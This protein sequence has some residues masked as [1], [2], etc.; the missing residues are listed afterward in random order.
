MP[1][2]KDFTFHQHDLARPQSLRLKLNQLAEAV[3]AL[4]GVPEPDVPCVAV[5]PSLVDSGSNDENKPAPYYL[6]PTH[7]T[8][9][10]RGKHGGYT[11]ADIARLV[12]VEGVT[13][14]NLGGKVTS[15]YEF[16]GNLGSPTAKPALSEP[17]HVGPI[18]P[19]E[20]KR[21]KH[22]RRR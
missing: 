6:P 22:R 1:V 2:D 18:Q 9:A 10:P 3:K 14:P 12:P 8:Q 20:Q 7:P 19:A 11:P 4:S 13:L 16:P 5:A 15:V 21:Q 17:A